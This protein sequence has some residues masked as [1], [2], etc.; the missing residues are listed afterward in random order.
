M[1]YYIISSTIFM[2]EIMSGRLQSWN[3]ISSAV[4]SFTPKILFKSCF[5]NFQLVAWYFMKFTPCFT[6]NRL[7]SFLYSRFHSLFFYDWRNN[8][9]IVPIIHITH[10]GLPPTLL[11]SLCCPRFYICS[12]TWYM[13]HYPLHIIF[14]FAV[15]H[16][17]WY[18]TLSISFLYL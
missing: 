5:L 3:I 14:V 1:K 15:L 4:P 13:I 17:T 2:I 12:V 9:S 7:A 10:C 18:T 6:H 8:Y 16:D 11:H